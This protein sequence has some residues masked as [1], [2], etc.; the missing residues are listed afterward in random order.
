VKFKSILP[1]AL[2]GL[3]LFALPKTARAGLKPVMVHYM[4][5]FVARPYSGNWGWH[6]TMNHAN[7]D[8]TNASG[9]REIAS[10]YHPLT[11]PGDSADPALLEYHVLLMKLAGVDGVMVDWYGPDEFNDYASNNRRTLALFDFTRKAGLKFALCYED[12]TIRQ[13]LNGNYIVPGDA[14]AHARQ[15]LLYAQSHFFTDASYLRLSNA[16]VLLNF[17][18]QYFKSSADW[19]AIFSG[20]EATNHPAFFTED[21]RL[22]VGVG[23]FDWPPMW[24]SGGGSNTLA[25]G[26]LENY[27][28]GFEKKA[29]HWPAFV[30]SA[31]PRFHDFYAQGGAGASNGSLDDAGGGT[32]INTLTRALTNN[33]AI[34]QIVTWND[35]GEGTVVEPTQE[36]GW[37]DL[38]IVQDLRHR[39]LDP[40]FPGHTNDLALAW[41]F[42]QLRQQQSRNPVMPAKLDL[43]F[44]NIVAGKIAAAN[45]ELTDL[46][47][48]SR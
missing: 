30:S 36:Y 15:A 18:P 16:P 17:G 24:L 44:T 27:L 12:Q 42:Y 14:L 47:T 23:A 19:E 33:S 2:F 6:W 25:P 37:R 35:F 48:K 31:F 32:L 21:T 22:A 10:W 1:F 40:G 9:E 29:A 11:G 26:Q 34:V 20:L 7:P 3:F 45:A 28:A 5:W 38:G 13:E 39:Y 4:P 43:I 8:V 41:R 46:E